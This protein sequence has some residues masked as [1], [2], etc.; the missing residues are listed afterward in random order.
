MFK[1]LFS[2]SQTLV[3]NKLGG[4]FIASFFARMRYSWSKLG[5]HT[6]RETDG[7]AGRQTDRLKEQTDGQSDRQT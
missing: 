5:R 6:G 7:K 4:Q 3:Q 2:S 1:N